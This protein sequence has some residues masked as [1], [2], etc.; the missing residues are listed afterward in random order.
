MLIVYEV[1]RRFAQVIAVLGDGFLP[2]Q[3]LK[4]THNIIWQVV[5]KAP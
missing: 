3:A 4:L 5:P 2:A 1:Q